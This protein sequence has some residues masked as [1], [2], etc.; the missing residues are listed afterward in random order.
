MSSVS[1]Y[2]EIK[3]G[4]RRKYDTKVCSSRAVQSEAV[5]PRARST[6][7]DRR[8]ISTSERG[9]TGARRRP[10]VIVI[11][12]SCVTCTRR[13]MQRLPWFLA[14]TTHE[15]PRSLLELAFVG[16]LHGQDDTATDQ[17]MSQQCPAA[18]DSHRAWVQSMYAQK[19][20]RTG[21]RELPVGDASPPPVEKS[22]SRASSQGTGA[23]EG[24]TSFDR[25]FA[26]Q[27]ERALALS[28]ETLVDLEYDER[29]VYRS[30]DMFAFSELAGEVEDEAP[31]YRSLGGL[32]NV[33]PAEPSF[34]SAE[35]ASDA[36]EAKW[37][38]TMPPLLKRQ[39]GGILR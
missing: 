23:E 2:R 32:L 16:D 25:R 28:P 33:P 36:A 27:L 18:F 19:A 20:A 26:S 6:R 31:V 11:V 17:S 1:I 22:S 4:V 3:P 21:K 15:P 12:I 7:A 29:P 5:L 30:L 38:D 39:R 10:F 24:S 9:R 13:Q 37:L 8:S 34:A 14:C 35:A